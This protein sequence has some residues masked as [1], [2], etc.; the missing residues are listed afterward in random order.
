MIE[1][2]KQIPN[3][4]WYMASDAGRIKSVNREVFRSD[5]K[6]QTFKEKILATPE[7]GNGYPCVNLSNDQGRRTF[8]VHRVVLVAFVG[9]CPHGFDGCHNNGDPSDCR[10]ENLRWDTH[11]SNL[12]DMVAHGRSSK[13][14]RHHNSKLSERQV[15]SI[16]KM[17]KDGIA[18]GPIA[19]AFG[20]G[21][22]C[23]SNIVSKKSWSHI[24]SE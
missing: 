22:K 4:P 10:L 20:V 21:R 9:E 1:K 18:H 14:E 12:G 19:I 8:R 7:D 2:W 16:R 11:K 23:V 17:A 3:Y 15:I 6:K 24:C 13:G 5:G